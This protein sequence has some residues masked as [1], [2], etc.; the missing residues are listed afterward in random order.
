MIH[1][2][3]VAGHKLTTQAVKMEHTTVVM[4]AAIKKKAEETGDEEKG[5]R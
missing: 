4:G 1:R 5:K 3:T 2:W